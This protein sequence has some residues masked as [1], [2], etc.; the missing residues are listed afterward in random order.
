MKEIVIKAPGTIA[1]LGPGFDIFALALEKPY[2]ELTMRLTDTDS[3][4]IKNA[5]EECV[6][7]CV[8]DNTGGLAIQDLLKKTGS[9]TGV[10]L[11]VKKNMC[12]GAGLGSSGACASA[13]VYGLNE[14]MG[15]QLNYNDMIEI[16]RKGEVA[17][18]NVA[19]ADNVAGAMLGGF[20][21]IKN[22]N[23]INVAKIDV[24]E[25]PIVIGI[26]KKAQRT[27]RP[28]IPKSFTLD[29]VKE[30]LSYCAHVVHSIVTGDIKE[31]GRSINKDY[32]SEPIRSKSIPGYYD[33]KKKLLAEKAY[34]CNICGGGSSIFVV[35]EKAQT[36]DIADVMG[37][38]FA[39]R[40]L[41]DNIIITKASNEGTKV[42]SQDE[43]R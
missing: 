2:L 32:I 6:P 43:K 13:C 17:S 14:L 37:K 34:G 1:N 15:L 4:V 7:T 29:E 21:I 31:F 12:I 30:Q 16:A 22:S 42:I 23:P 24:A 20:V 35:C 38:E 3:V 11:E 28:L 39:E 26:L 36:H 19:H 10:S 40:E 18:G 27:T 33:I 9:H 41:G 8:K 5:C 25:I